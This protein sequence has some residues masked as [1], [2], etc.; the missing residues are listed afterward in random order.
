MNCW[1]SSLPDNSNKRLPKL[2]S[3]ARNLPAK[4]FFLLIKKMVSLQ[5][6]IVHGSSFSFADKSLNIMRLMD[7]AAPN[8]P[9]WYVLE[10]R[11]D[12]ARRKQVC[13]NSWNYATVDIRSSLCVFERPKS[14]KT[15]RFKL[16]VHAKCLI[17]CIRWI[18]TSDSHCGPPRISTD[19][20]RAP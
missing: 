17:P 6:T 11:T 8:V 9:V 18:Y 12:N 3:P 20:Q 5:E 1:F 13:K 16:C 4:R 7:N 15:H 10:I 2:F 14:I 19:R